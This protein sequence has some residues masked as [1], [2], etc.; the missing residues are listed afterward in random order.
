MTSRGR[1]TVI[2]KKGCLTC[3]GAGAA[4]PFEEVTG[5]DDYCECVLS[6]LLYDEDFD[7]LAAGE[8]EVV[9]ND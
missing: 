7:A 4:V 9:S 1:G 3:G 5:A 8:I 6:Q 2:A